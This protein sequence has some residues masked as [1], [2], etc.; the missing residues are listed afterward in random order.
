MVFTETGRLKMQRP[1]ITKQQSKKQSSEILNKPLI[2]VRILSDNPTA[3]ESK[4]GFRNRHNSYGWR[5]EIIL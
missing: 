5:L 2:L 3:T 4:S 1:D